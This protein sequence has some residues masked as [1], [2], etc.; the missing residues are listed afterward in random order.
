MYE[1]EIIKFNKHQYHDYYSSRYNNKNIKSFKH[2]LYEFRKYFFDH[3]TI[4][5]FIKIFIGF[6]F[7]GLP[8]FL[9]KQILSNSNQIEKDKEYSNYF[10]AIFPLLIAVGFLLLLVSFM[11]GYKC[12]YL[13][14]NS[15]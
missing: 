7:F 14:K 15:L 1:G 11:M 8:I 13:I 5:I 9:F 2:F 10:S 3:N 12:I 4:Y 6:I